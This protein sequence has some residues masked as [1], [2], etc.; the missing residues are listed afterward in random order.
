[1]SAC[2]E[3]QVGVDFDGQVGSLC[4]VR[5]VAPVVDDQRPAFSVVRR[6]FDLNG[7]KSLLLPLLVPVAVFGLCQRVGDDDTGKGKVGN[8]T[9]QCLLVEQLLLHVA[10][11]ACLRLL[12][13]LETSL[14][15]DGCQYVGCIGRIGR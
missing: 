2:A 13:G 1:M 4:V 6:A 11:D 3:G 8:G 10:D 15:R 12:E 7:L 9:V 5:Q 14:R